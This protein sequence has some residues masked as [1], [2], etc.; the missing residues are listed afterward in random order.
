MAKEPITEKSEGVHPDYE[1]PI[2][3]FNEP[4]ITQQ[5]RQLDDFIEMCQEYLFR[6]KLSIFEN[7]TE[8]DGEGNGSLNM[9]V[10]GPELLYDYIE[11]AGAFFSE[12]TYYMINSIVANHQ[13]DCTEAGVSAM[14][15]LLNLCREHPQYMLSGNYVGGGIISQTTHERMEL[16]RSLS[17]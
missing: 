14:L 5:M 2:F 6:H 1:Q 4:V 10:E 17:E 7:E 16:L 11:T 12:N 8:E 15:T 13:E 3:G 9:M